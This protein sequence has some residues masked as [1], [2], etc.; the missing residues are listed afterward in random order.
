MKYVEKLETISVESLTA[1]YNECLYKKN[2]KVKLRTNT[3]VFTSTIKNV[4]A[5]G[6]LHTFDTMDREFNFGEVEWVI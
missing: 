2:E 6:V 4:D 1:Q 3:M 5:R